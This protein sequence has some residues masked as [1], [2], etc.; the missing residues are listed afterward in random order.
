MISQKSDSLCLL[1]PKLRDA[2]FPEK[3]AIIVNLFQFPKVMKM[4]LWV[5]MT[6]PKQVIICQLHVWYCLFWL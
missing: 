3:P 4:R 5:L 1:F 2:L 6:T